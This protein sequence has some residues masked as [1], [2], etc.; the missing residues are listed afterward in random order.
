MPTKPTERAL[1]A[2]LGT[3]EAIIFLW[4]AVHNVGCGSYQ[5]TDCKDAWSA[6]YDRGCVVF[7]DDGTGMHGV[8]LDDAIW[9]CESVDT[10]RDDLH[11]ALVCIEGA[12]GCSDCGSVFGDL[13]DCLRKDQP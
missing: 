3:L 11:T 9:W 4:G 5:S 13:A 1:W 12:D 8:A 6:Y 10:C 7:V 2:A